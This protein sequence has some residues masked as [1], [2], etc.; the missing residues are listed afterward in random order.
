MPTAY[1]NPTSDV[2][3]SPAWSIGLGSDVYARL[4][5]ITPTGSPNLDGDVISATASGKKCVIGFSDFDNTGVGSINSVRAQMVTGNTARGGNYAI[6]MRIL[7]SGT[8]SAVWA[9]EVVSTFASVSY[10]TL[11]WSA[12][13]TS[14]SGGSAWNDTDL[15]NI[16][17]E[18]HLDSI[19]AGTTKVTRAWFKIDYSLA[20]T[21]NAIF[22]GTNF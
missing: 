4:D 21:D 12:R 19:N 9:E 20:A 7:N 22:F 11:S 16:Q 10:R 15:D 5:G 2:S 14:S 3:N 6:G 13:T 8:G 1:L 18:I 17:M